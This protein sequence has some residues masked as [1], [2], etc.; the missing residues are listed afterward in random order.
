[1]QLDFSIIIPGFTTASFGTAQQN[2]LCGA[3][4]NNWSSATSAVSCT[5]GSVSA[6]NGTSVLVSGYAYFTYSAIPSITD[7]QTAAALRDARIV[8]LTTNVSNVLGAV[9][10]AA[11]PNCACSGPSTVVST[12][13]TTPLS[14][15][16]N[17]TGIPGPMQCA[18]KLNNDGTINGMVSQ[19]GVDSVT[20]KYCSTPAVVG[21][22]VGIPGSGTCVQYGVVATAPSAVQATATVSIGTGA[23]VGQVIGQL[24][25][26][27]GSGYTSAPT[28][29]VSA[30]NPLA[31]Q[32]LFTLS[33]A[34]APVPSIDA[35]NGP[36]TAYPL[37]NTV[38]GGIC[39]DPTNTICTTAGG[40]ITISNTLYTGST[41]TAA[42]WNTILALSVSP[43]G[44]VSTTALPALVCAAAPTL[45]LYTNTLQ[46]GVTAVL[47]ASVTSGAVSGISVLSPGS[48]Y[49]TAPTVTIGAPNGG[50][51]VGKLCGPA[52][53]PNLPNAIT[54]ATSI[55]PTGSCQPLGRDT[56]LNQVC[57]IPAAPGG[58]YEPLNVGNCNVVSS[59]IAQPGSTVTSAC[60]VVPQS[61]VVTATAA[62]A[63]APTPAPA[64]K[65]TPAPSPTPAPVPAPAAACAYVGTYNIESVACPTKFI[66][67]NNDPKSNNAC[68]NSTL[69][70]RTDSQSKGARKYWKLQATAVAGTV[71]TASAQIAVGRTDKCVDDKY[72]NLAAANSSPTPRLAGSGWKNRIIPVDASKG[73]DT[74]WIQA[75]GDNPFAGK[76]L[77][78][79]SCSSQT[80]FKWD[81]AS[82]S[83]AIQWKLSKV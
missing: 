72:T 30:P 55:T 9:Y 6:Y 1:M 57:S 13:S 63:P 75:V 31:A 2:S 44:V 3:I 82:S 81:A 20:Q 8:Q 18:Y 32:V 43:A 37:V 59:F 79:G 33:T 56:Y 48:G 51:N 35:N 41:C 62:P 71:P 10:P 76:Y 28:V 65:P 50:T 70:L 5:V 42:N 29:T 78:Y 66:A 47:S 83:S 16:T 25:L 53:I 68:K 24:V 67:Y 27:G 64:P 34:S 46:V 4:T 40:S 15:A 14:Y 26:T 17:I 74:V 38:G 45:T 7:L 21:G 22:V 23:T 80:A 61:F 77:G 52:P 69:M 60:G 49:R 12:P 39:I 11:V 73:C 58:V 19:I 36:Y 54:T